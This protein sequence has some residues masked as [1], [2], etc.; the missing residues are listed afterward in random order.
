M[1][2]GRPAPHLETERL[3]LRETRAEDFEACAALW[4]DERVVRHI[5]GVPSTAADS[6]GR[7][8]RFPGLWALVGYGYWTLEERATGVFAGQVGFADFKRDLSVDIAGVPE[9][10]WVLSPDVHGKGYATEAMTAALAWLDA[11]VKADQSCCLIAPA[12]AASIRVAEKLGY[13]AM[14]QALLAGE[15]ETLVLW[16]PRGVQIAPM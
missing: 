11:E 4:A 3:I 1:S 13:G 14:Q 10:G 5:S 2:A 9:A 7:M 8:L 15:H 12:N 6:W 16:R